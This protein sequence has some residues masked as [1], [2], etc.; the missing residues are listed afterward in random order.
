MHT[1]HWNT[2][3]FPASSKCASGYYG[4][5][6]TSPSVRLKL[7]DCLVIVMEREREEEVGGVS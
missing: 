4:D 6:D 2:S 5:S 7:R 1:V 3:T